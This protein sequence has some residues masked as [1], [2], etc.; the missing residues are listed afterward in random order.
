VFWSCREGKKRLR[1]GDDLGAPLVPAL[2][3]FKELLADRSEPLIGFGLVSKDS[4][5][6]DD[7]ISG[8]KRVSDDGVPSQT[9]S[10]P[11][12]FSIFVKELICVP[13]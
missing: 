8:A 4:S 11:L 1:L 5:C 9:F 2:A 12:F 6:C 3:E 7:S 13:L 10:S